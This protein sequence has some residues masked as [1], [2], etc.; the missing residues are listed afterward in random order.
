MH[1]VPVPFQ[2]FGKF[3]EVPVVPMQNVSDAESRG[4]DFAEH[5]EKFIF[6][7]IRL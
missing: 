5:A 2:V 3:H 1:L 4:H 7:V 6:R